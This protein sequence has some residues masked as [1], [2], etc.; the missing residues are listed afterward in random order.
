RHELVGVGI[1]SVLA[2]VP[3]GER[4]GVAILIDGAHAP[5]AAEGEVDGEAAGVAEAV[6]RL[7][8]LRVATQGEAVLALVEEE[9]GL[10]PAPDVD[11]E[12][13]A[14]ILADPHQLRRRLAPVHP[15]LRRALLALDVVATD[16]LPAEDA[17]HAGHL[18]AQRR[19]DRRQVLPEPGAVELRHEEVAVAIDDQ[20]RQAVALA[21]D[22]AV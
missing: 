9:A 7:P 21:V 20:A 1:E 15:A 6:Q 17:A 8:P 4:N 2:E 22:H 3:H 14:A 13:G 10:L 12:A 16:L 18:G 5:R 11:E 19:Q